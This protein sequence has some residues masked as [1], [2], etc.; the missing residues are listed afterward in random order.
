M[1]VRVEQTDKMSFDDISHILSIYRDTHFGLKFKG[2]D[3]KALA[4]LAVAF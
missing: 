3:S 1:F 2:F 4:N